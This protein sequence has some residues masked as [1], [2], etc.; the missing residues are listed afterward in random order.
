MT[1]LSDPSKPPHLSTAPNPTVPDTLGATPARPVDTASRHAAQR[2]L[3]AVL[4]AH[5]GWDKASSRGKQAMS[6]ATNQLL[7]LQEVERGGDWG[8]LTHFHELPD[9]VAA[10]LRRRAATE[11]GRLAAAHEELC[12]HFCAMRDAAAQ[13]RAL[14]DKCHPAGPAETAAE[15]LVHQVLTLRQAVR[16][17]REMSSMYGKELVAKRLLLHS[18]TAHH[19]RGSDD[20]AGGEALDRDIAAVYV[21][22]WMLQPLLRRPHIDMVVAAFKSEVRGDTP[23]CRHGAAR[24]IC[25]WR[26]HRWT[27]WVRWPAHRWLGAAL[28]T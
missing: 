24:L 23:H 5:K 2:Q 12:D 8:A 21:S 14:Q 1:T 13:L 10:A 11:L 16:Y 4:R 26:C 3:L 18:L 19:E 25:C 15:L 20:D 9:R 6:A 22:S 17:A 28:S 27:T 7:L